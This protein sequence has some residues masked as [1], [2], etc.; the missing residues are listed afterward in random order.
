MV[1]PPVVDSDVVDFGFDEGD[2]LEV[3][4]PFLADWAAS[5]LTLFLS[6]S[7]ILLS[8]P[9]LNTFCT[10]SLKSDCDTVRWSDANV[11]EDNEFIIAFGSPLLL[12]QSRI[13]AIFDSSNVLVNLAC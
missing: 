6:S 11:S 5:C 8:L 4:D 13:S 12:R 9:L 7:T 2:D 10:N 1:V 3:F